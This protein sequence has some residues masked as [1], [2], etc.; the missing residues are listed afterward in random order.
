MSDMTDTEQGAPLIQPEQARS[1]H[2]EEQWWRSAA[3]KLYSAIANCGLGILFG[4][5][6]AIGLKVHSSALVFQLV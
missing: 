6:T 1:V 4:A 5:L 3:R 2:E